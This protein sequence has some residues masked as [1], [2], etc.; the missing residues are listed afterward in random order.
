MYDSTY[1]RLMQWDGK[2]WNIATNVV[3]EEDLRNKHPGLQEL[4][5]QYIDAKEKYDAMLALVK[6]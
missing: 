5:A 3:T 1:D 6:E 2:A 4:Y